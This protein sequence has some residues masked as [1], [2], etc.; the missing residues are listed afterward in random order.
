MEA[1]ARKQTRAASEAAALGTYS[2]HEI[3][4]SNQDI[5]E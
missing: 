2:D 5:L 4:H 3:W 1:T